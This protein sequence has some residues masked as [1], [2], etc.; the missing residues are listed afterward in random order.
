MTVQVGI[1]AGSKAEQFAFLM[2]LLGIQKEAVLTGSGL[3]TP[4]EIYNTLK[5]VVAIGNLKSIE[6]YFTDPAKSPPPE[7]PPDPKLVEVEGKMKA[8]EAEL[9]MKAQSDQADAQAQ[10]QRDQVEAALRREEMERKFAMDQQQMAAEFEL[11]RQQLVE[12]LKL[13]RELGMINAAT[14]AST[15]TSQVRMGGKPG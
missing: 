15:A 7:R 8:K 1:S 13:K 2:Q 4:K 14:Q 9:A 11:K 3:A 12:E 10:M 6:P 5:K